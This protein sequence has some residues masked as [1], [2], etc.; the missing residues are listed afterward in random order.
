MWTDYNIHDPG[1]TI[2]EA[3]CYALTDVAY[4]AGWDINDLLMPEPNKP[5]SKQPFF[6]AREILTVNPWTPDDFRRLLIDLE[7]VRNAWVFC[8]KCACDVSYYAWCEKDQL[9]LSYQKPEHNCP[10]RLKKLN[11]RVYMMCFLNWKPTR[12]WAT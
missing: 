6:T 7:S 11:L 8:K 3:L 4:R 2:L 12:N 10:Y 1:I 9:K 5:F